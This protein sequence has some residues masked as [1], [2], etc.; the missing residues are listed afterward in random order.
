MLEGEDDAVQPTEHLA[1]LEEKS[2][3][4][5]VSKRNKIRRSTF[6]RVTMIGK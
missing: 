3:P 1:M 2:I 5:D 6:P 4:I